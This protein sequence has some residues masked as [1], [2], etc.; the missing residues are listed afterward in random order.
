MTHKQFIE[1]MSFHYAGQAIKQAYVLI[2]GLDVIGN[3]YGLVIGTIKG[4]ED[5]FYEPFLGAIQGPG[6]FAEGL[7]LG[8]RSMLGHTVGGVAEAVSKITG[9]MGK[10]IAV[11]TFDKEYQ[12]RR[13]QQ[14]HKRPANLQEGLAQ[15]GKGLIMGVV[16][17]ITGIVTQ[18]VSGAKK[19]GVEGFF[20]GFGKGVVGLVTRPTAGIV[21]FASGSFGAVKRATELEEEIK[22]VRS[23]RF[24]QPDG[25]VRPYI[26]SEADGNKIL[27]EVE[28]G[29]Y[30]NTDVYF[31]YMYFQK[32]V[33]LLTDKRLLYLEYN[34]LFGG[35]RVH[36]TYT[37]NDFIESPKIVERGV[38]IFVT[39]IKKKKLGLFGA[40]TYRKSKTLLIVDDEIKELLCNKIQKQLSQY[41]I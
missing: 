40:V 3:P 26:K 37:W 25:L 11:L 20:K 7:F 34:D 1:E 5:L 28:K 35:W 24:L 14:L 4:I 18:P 41:K 12:R 19:E 31:H 16:D 36:W 6:E 33:L 17:G 32:D 38:Q 30:A 8:M 27:K 29:K 2:L 13:L 21:D 23:P 9:A 39:E 22:R 15:S 10:G